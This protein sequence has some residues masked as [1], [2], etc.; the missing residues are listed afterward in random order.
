MIPRSLLVEQGRRY[1]RAT[2]LGGSIWELSFATQDLRT[3][4]RAAQSHVVDLDRADSPV[5]A[6]LAVD[7]G[8]VV[9][10][11]VEHGLELRQS[12]SADGKK[13]VVEVWTLG[14]ARLARRTV[15]GVGPRLMSPGVFGTPKFSPSGAAVTFVAERTP[16][17][18]AAS[19]YWPD[20]P[21]KAAPQAD[22]T[23]AADTQSGLLAGRFALADS[24]STGTLQRAHTLRPRARAQPWRASLHALRRAGPLCHVLFAR[25]LCPQSAHKY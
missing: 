4:S 10:R 18:A 19:G 2:P 12:A 1:T 24:R 5:G 11:S 22:A 15:D 14:G 16:D 3:K 21:P 25:T 13:L 6:T 23:K 7:A 8:T 17:G 9:T 20:A